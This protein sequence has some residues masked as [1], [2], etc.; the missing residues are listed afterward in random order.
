MWTW[1]KLAASSI[2]TFLLPFVRIFL[3]SIGPALVAA[4]T[5]AVAT[6]AANMSGATGAEKRDAAYK[7]ILNDLKRQGIEATALM[8]NSAIEAAVAKLNDK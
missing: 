2:G 1:I 3:T 4:S 5:Q 7:I 8:I 6:T